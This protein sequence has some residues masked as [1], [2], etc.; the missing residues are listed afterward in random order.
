MSIYWVKTWKNTAPE[1][2]DGYEWSA[3]DGRLAGWTAGS[4]FDAVKE[5]RE[6]L[7]AREALISA[8]ENR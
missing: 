2:R 5:A 3:L 7:T 6:G 8:V 1:L 4:R